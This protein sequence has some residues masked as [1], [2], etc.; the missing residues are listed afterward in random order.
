MYWLV[1]NDGREEVH[2][3]EKHRLWVW[4]A[5]ETPL[6]ER[7]EESETLSG[8]W[9]KVHLQ[10]K[11]DEFET[12]G[13]GLR[14]GWGRHRRCTYRRLWVRTGGRYIW[15]KR[16]RSPKLVSGSTRD[17]RRFSCKKSGWVRVWVHRE[18]L[19]TRELS[20]VKLRE[21]TW[22]LRGRWRR[23]P[24]LQAERDGW[25]STILVWEVIP[26]LSLHFL[27]CQRNSV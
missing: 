10:K 20:R 19:S 12:V 8:I 9:R 22:W 16:G 6:R 23:S 5:V 24:C 27:E 14:G 21:V 18:D 17:G 26:F 1:S 2:L 13:H 15:E 11:W 3:W 25:I 7:W 4:P